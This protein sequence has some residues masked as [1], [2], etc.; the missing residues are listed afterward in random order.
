MYTYI[1][2]YIHIYTYMCIYIYIYMYMYIYIYIYIYMYIHIYRYT[3]TDINTY[4]C[5]Y[6]YIYTGVAPT[7]NPP[8]APKTAPFAF[9]L[10]LGK[11]EPLL[12]TKLAKI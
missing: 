2:I 3:Y 9:S 11:Y 5:I 8:T 7:F 6:I 12:T 10:L 4:I 1:C